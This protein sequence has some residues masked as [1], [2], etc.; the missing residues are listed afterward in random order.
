MLQKDYCEGP[1]VFKVAEADWQRRALSEYKL[2][3]ALLI[4]FL[5]DFASLSVRVTNTELRPKSRITQLEYVS[6]SCFDLLSFAV[7]CLS[8]S[9]RN[10]TISVTFFALSLRLAFNAF[11]LFSSDVVATKQKPASRR[12]W[13]V[14]FATVLDS[15]QTSQS[16]GKQVRFTGTAPVNLSS[17]LSLTPSRSR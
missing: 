8:A 5:F 7:I 13:L 1:I 11:S 4:D 15:L 9:N 12:A 17:L 3:Q 14:A 6:R 16:H 10:D 2:V